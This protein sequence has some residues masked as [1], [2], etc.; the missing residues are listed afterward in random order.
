LQFLDDD[1]IETKI[2]LIEFTLNATTLGACPMKRYMSHD[3][4]LEEVSEQS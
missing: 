3:E 2:S 1:R 4:E